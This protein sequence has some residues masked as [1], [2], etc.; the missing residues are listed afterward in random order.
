MY[1]FSYTF[2]KQGTHQ[3]RARIY[4]GPENIG[5]ASAPVTITVTGVAPVTSLP[6][7]S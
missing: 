5:A 4:G 7:A 1:S 2:G 6:P 3:L